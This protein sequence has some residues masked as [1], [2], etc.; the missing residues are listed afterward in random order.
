MNAAQIMT[1]NPVTVR[2]ETPI[3]E[4]VSLFVEKRISGLPVLDAADRL[5]GIVTEGD[6]LRRAE[7]GTEREPHWLEILFA[8][9]R[10]AGEYVHTHG[11]TV[12]DVMTRN[13]TAVTAEAPLAVIVRLM[14]D[15]HIRRVP[16]LD[17]PDGTLVGIIS[18]AD[19]VRALGRVLAEQP[20]PLA[21]DAEI[22]ERILAE[23]AKQPWA[24]SM[25]DIAITVTNGTVELQGV[26]LHDE[27]HKALGVLAAAVPGVK[28]VQ[29]ELAWVE[30]TTGGLIPS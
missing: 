25:R 1:A 21:T 14:E 12:A 7:T 5:V 30:P 18:R 29:D 13:V 8:Y 2:P 27:Q 23:I 11:R 15:R 20:A 26:I 16:V 4:A 24:P 19:L 17:R 6:L 10:L 22:R 3:A 28:A 9:P